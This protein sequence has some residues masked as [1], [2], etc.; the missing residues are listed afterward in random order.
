M[1]FLRHAL[2]LAAACAL[3]AP[4]LAAQKPG[5]SYREFPAYGFKFKPLDAWLDVP[6]QPSEQ[7][8]GVVAQLDA[9]KPIYVKVEGGDRPSF[10]PSLLVVKVDPPKAET[11]GETPEGGLRGKVDREKGKETG[12]RDVIL[13]FFAGL[14]EAEFA[15]VVPET[16]TVK[17]IKELSLH[18]ELYVTYLV[19]GN[20]IGLDLVID[21]WVLDLSGTKFFFLWDY[22]VQERKDWQKAVEK[23]MKTLR[24]DEVVDATVTRLDE[25]SSYAD[26]YA[27]HA[28]EVAQT[29]GWRVEETPSKRFLIKTNVEDKKKIGEVIKRLE[30]SRDLFEEDFPPSEPIT[31]VSPVRICA[32][33]DEFHKYGKTGS[34]VAGWF[35]PRTTELVLF[36]S[37]DRGVEATMSVMSHEGF[38]Q[39]CHF[40]FH[41]AEAHRWF[42]EGHGDFYGAFNLKG[43]RL[44]S[45]D[46]MPGGLD[47]RPEI[48]DMINDGTVK[49]LSAHLRFDHGEWQSQGPS[50]VSGYAQSWSIIYFLRMGARGK[51]SSKYWDKEYANIIPNYIK[52][53]SEEY[54]IALEQLRLEKQQML[55]SLIDSGA[56]PEEIKELEDFIKSIKLGQ[57]ARD[58]IWNKAM[59]ESWGKIDEIEFE[60]RWKAFVLDVI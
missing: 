27:F 12:V 43:N 54:K 58:E 6:V 25:N 59:A 16:E 2:L 3:S 49:P 20:G 51:V 11:G 13:D 55:D 44:V 24:L 17:L 4:D 42:D 28:N 15:E 22:P 57:Q 48:K 34:G 35:N 52:V 5:R 30:A 50:P 37:A 10:K 21:C 60:Q 38:H 1:K 29:P 33:E 47:R 39:Y 8:R 14:R 9:E 56:P 36:F 31:H 7:G 53:L 18:H 19:S 46:K 41:E 23:S 45:D 40:L 32:T 26:A